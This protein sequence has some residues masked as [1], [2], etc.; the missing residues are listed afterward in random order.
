M[1]NDRV[2]QRDGNSIITVT[3]WPKRVGSLSP[4]A[5]LSTGHVALQ[6]YTNNE[7]GQNEYISFW[8]GVCRSSY[9]DPTNPSDPNFEKPGYQCCCNNDQSH[10]HTEQVDRRMLG[11]APVEGQFRLSSL[12]VDVLNTEFAKF[13]QSSF[14]WSI[15]G[16]LFLGNEY[17]T[18]SSL[19]YHLLKKAGIE[20]LIGFFEQLRL[21][22]ESWMP[23]RESLF[24]YGGTALFG[25][26]SSSFFYPNAIT[27][28]LR[29][30]NIIVTQRGLTSLARGHWQYGLLNLITTMLSA[31]RIFVGTPAFIAL[32]TLVIVVNHYVTPTIAAI[33]TVA[34]VT[35]DDVANIVK[36][37]EILEE[38]MSAQPN[39]SGSTARLSGR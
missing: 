22:A 21:R 1:D 37:I 33:G 38:S 35:P 4:G 18:C 23:S 9:Y 20:E 28:N 10:L 2:M 29:T 3:V 8:P 14:E 30:T 12:N 39:I 24:L 19:A 16:S 26:M 31:G 6:T 15:L 5:W 34:I 32:M 13:K 7:V 17:K 11:S 36:Q 27:N 25:L